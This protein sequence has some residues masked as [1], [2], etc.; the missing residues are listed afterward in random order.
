MT[1]G[2]KRRRRPV[3]EAVP[4]VLMPGTGLSEV[5]WGAEKLEVAR[6]VGLF[7]AGEGSSRCLR[8]L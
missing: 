5:L 6:A 3:W 8:F 2:M 7:M 1:C 4:V